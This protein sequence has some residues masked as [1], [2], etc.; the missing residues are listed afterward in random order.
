MRTKQQMP[1]LNNYTASAIVDECAPI[2]E[3]Y[4]QLD[5]LTK[6]Y[7]AGLKARL[8]EEMRIDPYTHEVK[9]EEYSATISEGSSSRM[10]KAKVEAFVKEMLDKGHITEEPDLYTSTDSL[11]IRF[12]KIEKPALAATATATATVKG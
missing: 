11:T 6:Y 2:Q 7:K 5:R 4:N 9:G 1:N 12:Y 8:T 10:D 3:Q